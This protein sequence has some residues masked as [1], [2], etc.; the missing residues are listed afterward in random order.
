MFMY[1]YNTKWQV[2]K[3]EPENKCKCKVVP[4]PPPQHEP[5][6]VGGPG[7]LHSSG[8]SEWTPQP[9]LAVKMFKKEFSQTV[10]NPEAYHLENSRHSNI[11]ENTGEPQFLRIISAS[12]C[13]SPSQ[14]LSRAA[15]WGRYM[16][17]RTHTCALAPGGTSTVALE[18][19]FRRWVFKCSNSCLSTLE[20]G[21]GA[22]KS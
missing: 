20:W 1:L 13:T 4:P 11:Y 17:T 19:G 2:K 8:G 22:E 9:I 6:S 14:A 12:S 7:P 16:R 10:S 18:S 3:A 15:A 5:S 21:W